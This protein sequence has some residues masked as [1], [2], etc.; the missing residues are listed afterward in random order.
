MT[1][2]NMEIFNQKVW[3]VSP[4]STQ[5]SV[6]I[7]KQVWTRLETIIKCQLALIEFVSE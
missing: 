5:I 1:R 6:Q 3:I 4:I 7:Y 2:A